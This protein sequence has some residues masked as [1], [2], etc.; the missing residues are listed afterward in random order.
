MFEKCSISF[1]T[2]HWDPGVFISV[3]RH[4]F[5][6]IWSLPQLLEST[7]GALLRR[8]RH[9]D[10]DRPYIAAKLTSLPETFTLG[11]EKTYSGFYNRPLLNNHY[12][13][14]VMAELKD[15]YPVITIEKQVLCQ[16]FIWSNNVETP[17]LCVCLLSFSFSE[18][19]ILNCRHTS[20]YS[21]SVLPKLC[22]NNQ[23]SSISFVCRTSISLNALPVPSAPFFH[24][25]LSQIKDSNSAPSQPWN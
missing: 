5:I 10:T 21:Y 8:R 14:F 4:K 15:Q 19:L 16:F 13:C 24:L 18:N 7:E 3:V 23:Q 20:S 12:Q 6:S 11:D 1:F 17:R 2:Y 22:P 9:T 25:L